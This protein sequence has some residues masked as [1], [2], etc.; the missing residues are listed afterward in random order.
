M[1][2]P[3][4]SPL[5]RGLLLLAIAL[6]APAGGIAPPRYDL[7]ILH[8]RVIDPASG[9]DRVA[10][11]AIAGGRIAAVTS[12]PPAGA[13]TISARGLVVA[14]GFIDLLAG[15]QAARDPLKVADGV[16]TALDTHRGPVDPTTWFR[17]TAAVGARIH[18]GTAV[19]HGALRAA[20]GLTDPREP[21]SPQ[22][23]RRMAALADRAIRAGALAIAFG[24]EYLPGTSGQ[25][26]VA[27]AEV[28]ARH[29]VPVHAH[30]RLPHL[31]DPFQGINELIAAAALTGARVHVMHIGSMAI[32]RQ[33][34]AL[35][36]LD[37]A[38]QRGI[39]IAADVYPYDAFMTRIESSLFD[40]GWQQ[41]YQLD[42]SDLVWPET[43]ERLTAESFERYRRQGGWVIA[44]QIPEAE[45]EWA[46]RHPW[47][48]IA[49]DGIY[50]E[51]NANHPR[52]AGTFARVLGH[53]V[54]ERK[55]LSLREALRK[56]TW[57]PA[58]RMSAAAPALARK[59]RIAAGMD[60]DLTLFDPAT[61]ID[62]ATYREPRRASAG[63]RYVIVGGR[64][65]VREGEVVPGAHAGRAII[66]GAARPRPRSPAPR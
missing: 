33:R 40:P 27:L 45:I 35:A 51:G 34:E 57:L 13:V 48:C 2:R 10:H 47:V 63:I 21:A 55:V 43:G 29:G 61:V 31:H 22:Q 52:S 37:R 23:V 16:T 41:K 32:H 12:H 24:I 53:Y 59:G 8:G 49:S 26:V 14:P 20:V 54:R 50:S 4:H 1:A 18:Y 9:M 64:I 19:G 44:H 7:V 56:M 39:D 17:E 5:L 66:S 28:A 60:A 62:R 38:R 11:L 58:Q 42:F 30:I 36:L 46:L 3:F 6:A 15:P 25:E 65:V